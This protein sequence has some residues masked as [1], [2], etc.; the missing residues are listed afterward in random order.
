[1]TGTMNSWRLE[2]PGSQDWERGV[3]PDAAKRLFVVDTDSHAN[4]PIDVFQQGGL[5]ERYHQRVPHMETDDRGAQWLIIEGWTPQLV[6]MAT[7]SQSEAVKA[8]EELGLE[9]S[10]QMWSDRMEEDDLRRMAAA[11]TRNA[12]TVGLVRRRSDADIDGIDVQI[13]FP[14]RGLLAF[15]TTD[16]DF[17]LAMV[18]AWN[19]WALAV[20]GARDKRF[21]PIPMIA[22]MKVEE[23]IAEVEWIAEQ[24]FT[25]ILLPSQPVFGPHLDGNPHY[26]HKMFNPLWE[27]I[28]RT[29]LPMCVH[30][31]TG[32]DPRAASGPGGAIFNLAVGSLT[33]VIEPLASF[34]TCGVF[35]RYPGLRLITVE[36]GIGWVPWLLQALDEGARKHHMWVRPVQEELPSYYYR[37][38]CAST[39]VEDEVGLSL[40]TELDLLD[41]VMWSS[42]YP[43]HEGSWPHSREAIERSLSRFD[44]GERAKIVGLNAARHFGIQVP[45]DR[46]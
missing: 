22:P 27:A 36:G 18:Q 3:R 21:R 37:K 23:S 8:Y 11:T 25:S 4:E 13:V 2:S 29:G 40:A 45:G 19:R 41:N 16:F 7:E 35:D 39:F 38:H 9:T 15:A 17:E 33:Q 26:N 44:D 6:K 34:L 42:D 12:D 10:G 24:G 31:A 30:V 32:R 14:G 1:M 43:H 20:Y 5:D 28:E 46:A